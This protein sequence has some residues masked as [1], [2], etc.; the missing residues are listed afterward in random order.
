M[1]HDE[2]LTITDPY[3][4]NQSELGDHKYIDARDDREFRKYCETRRREEDEAYFAEYGT[5][6]RQW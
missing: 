2:N 5:Y 6:E 1:N 3:S 4:Y